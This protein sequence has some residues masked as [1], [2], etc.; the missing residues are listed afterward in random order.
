MSTPEPGAPPEPAPPGLLAS[1]RNLI[2]TA[3][4]VLR[5]RLDL[6]ATEAEEAKL[7]LASIFFWGVL[8][9]VFLSIG[10]VMLTLLIAVVLWD[11]HRVQVVAMLA[12]GY[13]ALGIGIIFWVRQQLRSAPKLFA[14]SLAELAKDQEQLTSRRVQ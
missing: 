6:L 7:R 10:L 12:I 8:A 1:L 13:F 2:A 4:G 14:A 3:I 9:L 11:T 5:T